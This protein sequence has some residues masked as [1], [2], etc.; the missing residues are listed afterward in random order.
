M[1]AFLIRLL[2][3]ARRPPWPAPSLV[4]PGHDGVASD[5]LAAP[6]STLAWISPATSS[7]CA[8]LWPSF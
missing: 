7:R 8:K 6:L 2:L 1:F 5:G 3:I 4:R